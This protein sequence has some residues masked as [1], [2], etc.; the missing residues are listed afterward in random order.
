MVVGFIRV[1][2]GSLVCSLMSPGSLGFTCVHSTRASCRNV[3]SF[4]LRYT[5][6]NLKVMGFIQVRVFSLVR[7]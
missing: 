3:H 7:S 4:S 5:P 1:R 6:E 2:V